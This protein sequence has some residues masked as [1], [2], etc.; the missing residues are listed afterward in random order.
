[1]FLKINGKENSG[2]PVVSFVDCCTTKI[3]K[4]L[5]HVLQ[6]YVKELRLCLKD[7]TGSLQ[8]LKIWKGFPK[9]TFL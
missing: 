1:M 7:S 8:K 4:K 5:D 6:P 9:K 2:K 3:S